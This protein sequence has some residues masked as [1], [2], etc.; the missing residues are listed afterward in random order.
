MERAEA[1]W[2][3]EENTAG[4]G[5]VT[6]LTFARDNATLAVSTMPE[7]RLWNASTGMPLG[8]PVRNSEFSIGVYAALSPDANLLA[9]IDP[10]TA[11]LLNLRTHQQVPLPGAEGAFAVRFS[12]DGSLLAVGTGS[13]VQLWDTASHRRLATLSSSGLAVGAVAFSA[14]GRLLVAAYTSG[15]IQ[16]W[17]V[18]TGKLVSGPIEGGGDT[19][20]SAV[21]SPDGT[22]IAV[23]TRSGTQ[24]VDVASHETDGASLSTGIAFSVAWSPDG[25]VLAV[26]TM[27]GIQLWNTATRQLIGDP[28]GSGQVVAL[29]WS[30]DGR[31]L[32]AGQ[33]TGAVQLWDVDG[34]IA[35]D[36]A[37]S[38]C[39]QAGQSLTRAQWSSIAPRVPYQ[40]V[41]P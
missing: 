30:S 2:L 31:T 1:A 37:S 14:D 9:A 3:T 15:G 10:L 4:A 40:D 23:G 17:D 41:C 18:A 19:T 5:D 39:A 20:Y 8:P 33:V 36:A 11:R 21:F 6:S 34:L 28:L 7:A 27:K 22:H 16:F 32:A 25:T 38:L 29:A 24:L 26:A 13:G 12:P 35:A